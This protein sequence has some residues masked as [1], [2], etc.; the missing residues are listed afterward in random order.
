MYK[1]RHDYRS[2]ITD[3]LHERTIARARTLVIT[4][5]ERRI[6]PSACFIRGT[7]FKILRQTHLWT[8]PLYLLL[9]QL[10]CGA[11]HVVGRRRTLH[12]ASAFPTYCRRL[13]ASL[14]PVDSQVILFHVLRTMQRSYRY[15]A[16]E[17]P[18]AELGDCT[19]SCSIR[20]YRQRSYRYC[21]REC[22]RAEL[23]D[24]TLSWQHTQL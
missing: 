11:P 2:L 13:S 7:K 3:S 6:K 1:S 24:C 18:R 5:T 21:A 23:G 4:C 15:C 19:L 10:K 9:Q 20:N 17:C 22:L 8:L 16:R 14:H 12:D